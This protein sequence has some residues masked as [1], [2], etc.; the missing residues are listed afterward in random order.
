MYNVVNFFPWL[1]SFQTSS[2]NLILSFVLDYD[3]VCKTEESKK[4]TSL[5]KV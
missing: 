3:Y 5:K 1:K 4:K 2:T